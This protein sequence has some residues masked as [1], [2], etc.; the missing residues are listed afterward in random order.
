[1]LIRH[2]HCRLH[3]GSAEFAGQQAM[4]WDIVWGLIIVCIMLVL[5]KAVHLWLK[6]PGSRCTYA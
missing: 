4:S 6:M 2:L 5:C 3:Y 1:M